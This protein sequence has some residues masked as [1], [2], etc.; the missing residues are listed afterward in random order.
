M[1]EEQ[2]KVAAPVEYTA[3]ELASIEELTGFFAKAPGQMALDDADADDGDL[4]QDDFT[5]DSDEVSGEPKRDPAAPKRPIADLSKFDDILS[6]DADSFDATTQTDAIDVPLDIPLDS[7]AEP[8]TNTDFDLGDAGIDLTPATSDALPS[9]DDTTPTD[10][11]PS[12]D[13]TPAADAL[14]SFDD[15]P[16]TDA[17]PSFD[18]TPTADA[19]PSFDDTPPTDALPSF[20][21]T[22][23]A[24]ALPSFDDT[25]PTDALPSFDDTTTADALPSF[26]DTPTAD[27]LPSFDDTTTADALPDFGDSLPES[28][29]LESA[30][31]APES[32]TP[33][34]A[35]NFDSAAP[36]LDDLSPSVGSSS[37]IDTSLSS[38]LSS[39]AEEQGSTM[40]PQ[41]LRRVR[42]TLRAFPLPLRRRLSHVLL[43][44]EMKPADSAELMRILSE[45]ASAAEVGAWLDS[46]NFKDVPETDDS[47]KEGPRIIMAR[48]EYTDDGLKR[49]ERIIRLTRFGAIA[50]FLALTLVGGVYFA[51]LKPMFYRNAVEKGRGMIM[52]S[53]RSAI[54]EAEKQFERALN[55]YKND[56][57]AYLQY[58]DAYRYKGLYAEAFGKLFG[59]VS[60]VGNLPSVKVGD[61]EVRSS[62]EIFGALK[63]VPV[64]KYAGNEKTIKVNGTDLALRKKGAYVVSHLDNAK[65]E[66]LVLLALGSFHSNPSPR[67]AREP[68]KNNF[69]GA[70]YYR[71][72]LMATP[73]MPTFKKEQVLDRAVMGIGDIFYHEKEYDRALDYYKKIVDKEPKN[74][75]ANA[76]IMKA[77]LKLF[78]LNDDPRLVIQQHT[79][80]RANKLEA[81]LPMY[82]KARLAAFYIDLP[83]ENELRIKYNISPQNMITG[84]ELKT[85]ADDLLNSIFN[86]SETDNFGV[87]HEGSRFAEGYYQRARAYAKDKNQVRMALKQFE[88]AFYY[89][90]RHFMALNDRAELLMQMG[91]YTDAMGLLKQAKE[92]STP[93]SLA[94]LGERE[95]D[96][97]LSEAS[98]GKISFNMGKAMYLDAVR[99]LAD[100]QTWLRLKEVQKYRSQTDE[101]RNAFLAQ[102]DRIENEF[103]DAERQGGLDTKT[104]TELLYYSGWTKFV[105]N[106][107]RAALADWE[108]IDP[109][110]AASLPNLSLAQSH[111]YYRLAVEEPNAPQREKYLDSA[112]GLLF[113][114]QDK[115]IA[116]VKTL[117]RVEPGNNLHA[118]LLSNLAIIENNIG[119]VYEMLDDEKNSLIHYWKSIENSKRIGQ[120]NEIANLN[121]R[122]SFKRKA[123]GEGENYPVIMDYVPP[124]VTSEM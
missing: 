80:L 12:F 28:G 49:Q 18:D 24:D 10:A 25:P 67:F 98:V 120:E 14:P 116:Q 95:E 7:G 4:P 76:G 17:L 50:A 91:N 64:V 62:A 30:A 78:A 46:R 35:F 83:K 23:T 81:K 59:E 31:F 85:R 72:I 114:A 1:A 108:K 88:Y 44:E 9:F 57:Y 93:E 97:T 119:A 20:D 52:T 70:D 89:N 48:P 118:R 55:Y 19:L 124:Q 33:D 63:R 112:L 36:S 101:G 43:E 56:T 92:L 45:E 99:D 102:L 86:S 90:P 69:L 115:Y 68:Y 110:K 77:L 54:P 22:P 2:E 106:D 47:D 103:E 26:D 100:S 27:A 8:A 71:R 65:D 122:L 104:N 42:Q 94:E 61:T 109:E 105:R 107:Y 13:D 34:T 11:L 111:C 121:I 75:A 41:T 38:D 3:E 32:H 15:T 40:D 60:L 16:A 113:Y 74:V 82:L 66:A 117:T 123:L 5:P 53:G 87:T 37:G 84:Q 79:L 21:D 73:A 51:L 39:L 96:E 58:A 29:G 6:A